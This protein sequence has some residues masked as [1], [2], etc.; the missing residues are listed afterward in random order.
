VIIFVGVAGSGKS[1]QGRLLA[2]SINGKYFSLG[3]YLRSHVDPSIKEKM[4]TG[5]L[6]DDQ[7]VINSIDEALP[8]EIFGA[9]EY[10]LDGFPR[11]LIQTD[12]LIDKLKRKRFNVRAVIHLKASP[13]IIVPRLLERKRPDDN[14]E[15][16]SLRINEYRD[17]IL[18]ILDKMKSVGMKVYDIDGENAIEEVHNDIINTIKLGS[19]I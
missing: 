12:W 16:I 14:V 15:A 7:E 11:T 18:P 6:I 1:I 13:E 4:L 2:Q 5:E 17:T 3:E 8:R 19:L 10:I 9:E